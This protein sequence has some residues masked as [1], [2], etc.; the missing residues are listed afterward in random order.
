MSDETGLK[1]M[2]VRP[3]GAP[4]G[5]RLNMALSSLQRASVARL[6]ATIEALLDEPQ[7]Q[8]ALSVLNHGTIEITVR[9]GRAV[10]IS[11]RTSLRRGKELSKDE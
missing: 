4:G 5:D 1:V 6:R 9:D 10:E 7:A 2:G 11:P 3:E 8:V